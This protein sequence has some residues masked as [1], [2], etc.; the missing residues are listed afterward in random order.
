MAD[1]SQQPRWR[2]IPFVPSL[3]DGRAPELRD[4]VDAEQMRREEEQPGGE[5][6]V[7]VWFLVNEYRHRGH[8]NYESNFCFRERHQTLD[9]I[10]DS[11]LALEAVFRVS[12]APTVWR[13]MGDFSRSKIDG[14]WSL[15]TSQPSRVLSG[16]TDQERRSCWHGGMWC[17][18]AS[19][20]LL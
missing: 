7:C 2:Q 20:V 8:Q 12:T 14:G 3:C 6:C 5:L 19:A 10:I 16:A 1:S 17:S 4:Q 18:D 11:D 9:S 13:K 15:G